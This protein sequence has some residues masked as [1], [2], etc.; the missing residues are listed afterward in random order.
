MTAAAN[1]LTI[2]I[3][4]GG[5]GRRMGE[6]T[7]DVPKPLVSFRGETI[8]DLKIQDYL[9]R[10]C[11]NLVLCIGYK[12][13]LIREAAERYRGE[14]N[15]QFSDAGEQA[16]ILQRLWHARQYWGERVLMTYG[17]T[18]TDLDVQQLVDH[19]DRSGHRATLVTA[20]IQNPFGLLEFERNGTIT[21][22]REKPV[23]N[24]Y[25]GQALIEHSALSL[26]S[27]EV[28][29]LE[30]G[31][32]LVTLFKI[33]IAFEAIGAYSHQGLDITFNTQTELAQMEE[34]FSGFFTARED[35][36]KR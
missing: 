6:L 35:P 31:R 25:I 18:F 26:V 13:D 15:L 5:R 8:L 10:G 21:Q 36:A 11:R 3:L 20:P 19:H 33:L 17:D 32:G 1:D 16:G 24:Y 28:I 29:G 9:R 30:D 27:D 12:G 14:A 7:S 22:F 34:K 2:A 4:C 23:L